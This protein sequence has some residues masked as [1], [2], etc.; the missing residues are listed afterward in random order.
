MNLTADSFLVQLYV[1]K[2]N[3]GVI[4]KEDVPALFNLKEEVYKLVP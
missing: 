4:S 3:E 2:I 1:K